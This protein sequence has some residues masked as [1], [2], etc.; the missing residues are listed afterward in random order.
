MIRRP[1]PDAV[2]GDIGHVQ[3]GALLRH[4]QL[5]HGR[6]HGAQIAEADLDIDLATVRVMEFGQFHLGPHDQAE[7]RIDVSGPIAG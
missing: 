6:A 7:Q 1:R 4:R 2:A 5:L 3:H